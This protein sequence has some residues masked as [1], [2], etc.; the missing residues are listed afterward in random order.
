MKK[1]LLIIIPIIATIA[2][3]GCEQFS[4]SYKRVDESEFRMLKYIW[5]PA[6][7]APGDTVTLT[8]VFAGKRVDLDSYLQ[9]WVSFNVIRDFIG[10]TT[11]VDSMLLKAESRLVDFSPNTQAVQF[12]IPVPGDIVRNSAS[13]PE[14]WIDALPVSLRGVLPLGIDTLTKT[15]IVDMIEALAGN[16]DNIGR[17]ETVALIPILQYFTVPMR[18]FTKMREP[19]RLP[20][21]INSTQYIRY[22]NRFEKIGVPVNT[23]P[24]VDKVVVYKAKGNI[25]GI[26]DKSGLTLDSIVLD[27]SGTSVITVEKGYSYFLDAQSNN[28]DTTVTMYG[29]KVPEKHRVYRQFQLDSTETA[30]VH[31]SKFMDIDNLN[32]KI[33]F[34]TNT[35][36]KKFVFWLTVYDEVQNERLRPNG[37]TLV[38]VSGR[39]EYK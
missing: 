3:V 12:K 18:V 33:T 11:V 27:N 10:S 4:T 7:A 36:I 2:M 5:E 30:G 24:K 34:P 14:M 6:D 1:I 8:A 37:E 17:E 16:I 13:V 23:A 20:H 15:R 26:D 28:I 9:W 32:G 21:T 22:N 38:E 19:G 29:N 31:H 25:S 39:L 35:K